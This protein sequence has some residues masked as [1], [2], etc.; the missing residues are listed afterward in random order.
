MTTGSAVKSWKRNLRMWSRRTKSSRLW[1]TK[2]SLSRTKWMSSGERA[3]RK[4]KKLGS[5]HAVIA[6]V[7]QT[8][9]NQW[10]DAKWKWNESEKRVWRDEA[11]QLVC[12]WTTILLFQTPPPPF[13]SVNVTWQ[14]E[15]AFFPS[16]GIRRTKCQSWRA[17]WNT[18]R[19]N[20]RTW[21]SSGDRWTDRLQQWPHA[22]SLQWAPIAICN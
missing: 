14:D 11:R 17:Q 1:P 13:F 7:K 5:Q 3:M 9:L 6:G 2:H 15:S 10:R 21:D 20:W 12:C 8:K 19:R 16:P 18:T 22:F 4:K